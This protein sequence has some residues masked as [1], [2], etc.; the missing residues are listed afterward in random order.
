MKKFSL[1]LLILFSFSYSYTYAEC[2]STGVDYFGNETIWCDD[3]NEYDLSTDIFGNTLM[4]GYN[5]NTGS[6]W[7]TEYG[8]SFLGPTMSGEDA[9][10]NY[11]DCYYSDLFT[12]WVC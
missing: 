12:E 8:D 4:E 1:I 9:D 11:F 5:S 7:Y 10:G 6:S 3:G 2:Y